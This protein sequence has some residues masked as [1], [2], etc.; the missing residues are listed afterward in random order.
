MPTS[1]SGPKSQ[2]AAARRAAEAQLKTLV[3][4]IAPAHQ[5]LAS[6]LRKALRKRLPTAHEIVYE[7]A[8]NVTISYS[9]NDKGYAGVLALRASADEVRLYFNQ[10]KGMTDPE[11]VLK[12][13]AKLVR[14][15]PVEGAS[16]LARPAVAA[17]I[18]Q[19]LA[20][21]PVPFA[22]TGDGP[23]VIQSLRAK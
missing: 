1:S 19:A 17:L 21:S 2:S 7:Y 14:W 8:D 4:K 22:K 16:T 18:D 15:I 3:D 23:V 5:R 6:A 13:S 12:G 9:P 11:K 10:G 20:R